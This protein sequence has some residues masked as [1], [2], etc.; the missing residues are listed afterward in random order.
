ML[1]LVVEV[2]KLSCGLDCAALAEAQQSGR[3]LEVKEI[4]GQETP[5]L[6]GRG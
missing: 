1:G 2:L 5:H 4:C 3:S 6:A